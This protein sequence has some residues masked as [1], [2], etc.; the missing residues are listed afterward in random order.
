M[1]KHLDHIFVICFFLI[2]FFFSTSYYWKT[3][4]QFSKEEKRYLQ[5]L[6]KLNQTSF[7]NGSYSKQL[8]TYL[9]DQIVGRNQF[10]EF[11]A[12]L[13]KLLLQLENHQVLF[14]KDQ[15][16][17]LQVLFQDDT[18]L[19]HNI[20]ALNQFPYPMTI[21]IVPTLAH[22][23][24][25]LLPKAAYSADE[26]QMLDYIEQQLSSKHRFLS[27]YD[28]L[29]GRNDAYFK[30]DHHWNSKGA[31]IGAQVYSS[32]R[33]HM[34]EDFHYQ[35]VMN[36]F[37]GSLI[38]KV[39]MFHSGYDTIDQVLELRDLDVSIRF[40]DGSTASS[41][42]FSKHLDGYDPYQYYLDG[43]HAYVEIKNNENQTGKQLLVIK[44]SFAHIMVPYLIPNY[45]TIYMIDLRYYKAKISDFLKKQKIDEILLLYNLKEF[46]ES[47]DLSFLK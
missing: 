28:S 30:T 6:P 3:D 47:K 2:V 45:D 34:L 29:K 4:Q 23:Q 32:S 31:Y 19:N 18:N 5:R 13:K 46:Y 39:G 21:M 25:N 36:T 1:K 33:N 40:E 20:Q 38:S 37:Q 12:N 27:L 15:T 44:D 22:M 16:Y 43:N 7:F 8:E 11:Y 42:Y 9:Q 26:K 35:P 41:I 17:M 10:I 24:E 14:G